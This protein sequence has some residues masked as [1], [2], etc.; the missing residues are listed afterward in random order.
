M[1]SEGI[2]CGFCCHSCF[3]SSGFAS[4][5]ISDCVTSCLYYQSGLLLTQSKVSLGHGHRE[6]E[7]VQSLVGLGGAICA[8]GEASSGS[9]PLRQGSLHTNTQPDRS[10]AAS[11]A[12]PRPPSAGILD[13]GL[14]SAVHRGEAGMRKNEFTNFRW[15]ECIVVAGTFQQQS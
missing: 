6:L 4:R 9:L 2:A 7:D 5:C 8:P 15:A 14:A 1:T 13:V 3:G 11:A 12:M 10:I